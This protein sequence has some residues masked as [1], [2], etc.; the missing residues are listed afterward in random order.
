MR[1][2]TELTMNYF[3]RVSLDHLLYPI[4]IGFPCNHDPFKFFKDF[5][6]IIVYNQEIDAFLDIHPQ[7]DFSKSQYLSWN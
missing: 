2:K 3:D 5:H 4:K 1:I 6:H 7:L